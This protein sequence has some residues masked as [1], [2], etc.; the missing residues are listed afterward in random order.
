MALA[1]LS[2]RIVPLPGV[3]LPSS[4]REIV[5]G[6]VAC[7]SSLSVGKK[8]VAYTTLPILVTNYAQECHSIASV[9]TIARFLASLANDIIR[10]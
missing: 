8:R 5:T 9:T 4:N 6:S 2:E 7:Q 1:V 3:P 10:N